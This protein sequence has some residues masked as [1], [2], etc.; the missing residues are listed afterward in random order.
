MTKVIAALTIFFA[1]ATFVSAPLSAADVN[2]KE[3]EWEATTQMVM[4]GM[5]F[6]M[7]PTKTYSC[8]T[9]DNMVIKPQEGC[10][11]IYQKVTGNTISY[12]FECTAEDGGKNEIEGEITYSGD[13]YKGHSTVKSS[14]G[15][16]RKDTVI[17]MNTTGRY[18]GKTCTETA[19]QEKQMAENKKQVA[20]I[21]QKVKDLDDRL[22]AERN[23]YLPLVEEARAFNPH[24]KEE[25]ACTMKDF[26]NESILSPACEATGKLN[27]QEGA[28]VFSSVGAKEMK[29]VKPPFD[30]TAGQ[31]EDLGGKCMGGEDILPPASETGAQDIKRIGNRITWK[32]KQPISDFKIEGDGEIT[33]N[34]D[35]ITVMAVK[36][37]TSLKD[38]TS[39]MDVK[40]ITGKRMSE[41]DAGKIVRSYTAGRIVWDTYATGCSGY[42]SSRKASRDY[43]AAGRGYTSA[44]RDYTTK[45]RESGADKA[46]NVL[47]GIRGIFGR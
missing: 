29:G 35:T 44:G 36:K 2:I 14:G 8:V 11:Q 20:E 12:K 28:W 1:M 26:K 13:S 18:L 19:K 25:G 42:K 41:E 43:T 5:P 3:G 27:L 30:I 40:K 46:R 23:K 47:K 34:G 4:E 10:K 33:Y 15:K 7:S 24:R 31:E 39:W 37:T 9:K 16:K 6:A 32:I 22:T 17:K 45:E 21:K 38:G